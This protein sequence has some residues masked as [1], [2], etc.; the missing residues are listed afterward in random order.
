MTA[1]RS[2]D[3]TRPS[4]WMRDL[5]PLH[6][7][8]R[9]Y[10]G[11]PDRMCENG[12]C[13]QERVVFFEVPDGAKAWEHLEA[14]LRA[15]WCEDTT[16]WLE[17]GAIYNVRSAREL[18]DENCSIAPLLRNENDLRL[19]E[20]GWGGRDGIGPEH[21]HY[22]RACDVDLFVTPRVAARLT[23]AVVEI[24]RLYATQAGAAA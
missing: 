9:A 14:L 1:P 2:T 16:D 8:H 4:V 15:A 7:L 12:R 21:I 18:F 20:S 10:V 3:R 11:L 22:S 5:V 17:N 19:F 23:L 13:L 24:E 6:R